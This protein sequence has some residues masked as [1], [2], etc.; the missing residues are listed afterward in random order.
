MRGMLDNDSGTRY[1]HCMRKHFCLLA[2]ISLVWAAS[3]WSVYAQQD[4]VI[5]NSRN[6]VVARIAGQNASC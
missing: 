5:M 6:V 3:P 1:K 4:T 2:R